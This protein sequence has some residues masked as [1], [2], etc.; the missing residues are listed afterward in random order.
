[1][2]PAIG[3][4][5]GKSILLG[6]AAMLAGIPHQALAAPIGTSTII[7]RTCMSATREAPMVSRARLA[8]FVL[9]D[10]GISPVDLPT[11]PG[12]DLG[13]RME[14][15]VVAAWLA[16]AGPVP[17]TKP[18]QQI[19]A[20]VQQLEAEIG[21]DSDLSFKNA[22]IRA[23]NPGLNHP[24]L[25]QSAENATLECYFE[26]EDKENSDAQPGGGPSL[27]LMLRKSVEDLAIAQDKFKEAESAKFGYTRMRSRAD[28]GTRKTDSTWTIDATLG[29][30][31]NEESAVLPQYAFVSYKRERARAKPAPTLPPGESQSDDDIDALEIGFGGGFLVGNNQ[32]TVNAS[33]VNDLAAD[34]SR[35]KFS[36]EFVPALLNASLGFCSLGQATV[37]FKGFASRC[38]IA[39]LAEASRVLKTGDATF[40]D[41][42][43]FLLAGG[44]L[45]WEL[46]PIGDDGPAASLFY[47]RQWRIAGTSPSIDR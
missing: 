7:A 4:A 38:T 14:K 2:I 41:N 17:P 46:L 34:S 37:Q 5:R 32:L 3:K 40:T 10:A 44:K 19:N 42:D 27:S 23:P 9:A 18:Q 45:G 6:G 47:R 36:A 11:D 24:W 35:L 22:G 12:L 13:A 15:A 8:G 26:E 1:M 33:V 30:R 16:E 39:F 28:D 20:V 31:I 25:F 43:E 29:L 21:S